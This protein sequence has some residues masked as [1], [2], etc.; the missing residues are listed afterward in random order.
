MTICSRLLV[1]SEPGEDGRTLDCEAKTDQPLADSCIPAFLIVFP[2]AAR[3]SFRVLRGGRVQSPVALPP[4][5]TSRDDSSF[6]T[7]S[8]TVDC[9]LWT[10][11]FLVKI[12][13]QEF[14]QAFERTPFRLNNSPFPH[15]AT[16]HCKTT[17]CRKQLS[18]NS[19]LMGGQLN[20]NT[21]FQTHNLI[22]DSMRRRRG[23]E[24]LT[25]S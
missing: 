1:A 15:C 6:R 18:E 23:N 17:P 9:G 25:F 13:N 21:S 20:R 14:R 7:A 2:L 12:Q 4:H 10:V 24:T 5:R 19:L 3:K 22:L 16:N 11:D 8:A